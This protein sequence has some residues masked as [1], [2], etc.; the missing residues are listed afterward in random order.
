MVLI[1]NQNITQLE[2]KGNSRALEREKISCD[3]NA[4]FVYK[5]FCEH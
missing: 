2:Q 3:V 4:F 5:N 1:V